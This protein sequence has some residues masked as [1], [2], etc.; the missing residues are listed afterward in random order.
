MDS[1]IKILTTLGIIAALGFVGKEYYALLTDLKNQKE[2]IKSQ[3][4]E[5]GEVVAMWV[6]KSASMED[7]KNYSAQLTAKK[8]ILD[9]EEERKLAEKREKITFN[10][11]IPHDGKP[12]GTIN[13]TLDASKST[14]TEPGDDMSWNWI[15]TDGKVSDFDPGSKEISFNAE[16]GQYNFQLTVTDSYGASSSEIR[17]VDVSAEENEAPKII[18]EKK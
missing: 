5:V 7:L 11:K 12:G 15:S 16:A 13:I 6:K 9:A 3:A 18:I 8:N 4:D 14:P 10:E 2:L 17:I 1:F